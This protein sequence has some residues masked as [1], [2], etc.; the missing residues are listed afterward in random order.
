M[1]GFIKSLE[2]PF[3]FLEQVENEANEE[4]DEEDGE[5]KTQ[6]EKMVKEMD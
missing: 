1:E 5:E 3:G 2:S 4:P 6:G